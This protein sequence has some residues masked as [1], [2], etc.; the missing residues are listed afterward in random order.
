[1]MIQIPDYRFGYRAVSLVKSE[2]AMKQ[3]VVNGLSALYYHDNI[4]ELVPDG[5]E[6]SRDNEIIQ[7]L[8]G[9]HEGDVFELS[10]E[11]ELYLYYN[12]SSEDNAFVLTNHCNS[13]CIMCPS[14]E[15]ARK[16][17]GAA[18]LQQLL[19][20]VKH[21]P[22][23]AI[24]LTITGGEPYLFGKGIFDFFSALR[25]RFP[26]TEF[27]L[28]T[29]GRV[30]SLP[31]YCYRTN[32]TLPLRT[33]IGI[34][35]HGPNSEIH[36]RITQVPGSFE[37]TN[38]GIKN[39]IA[40]G[41][42]VELRIVVSQLNADYLSQIATLFVQSYKGA[43]SV[44]IMGLEMLG[45][46]AINRA[47]VWLPYRD[48][49]QKAKEAINTLIAHGF[50]VKLY[51]FPLCSVEPAYWSIC[52]KSISEDKVRY[53]ETCEQCRVKDACG[54]LFAGT[55]RLAKEDVEPIRSD[56]NDLFF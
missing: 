11:G 44:K 41:R 35:I 19:D 51:N 33:L 47:R 20:L 25:E 6:V 36:D 43:Q 12:T 28:L 40:L 34:P 22:T 32:E 55:F 21:I 30:F 15:I 52:A 49:F 7:Q 26:E 16:T 50:D 39:M 1:M 13:N 5:V 31:E 10:A 18:S 56:T 2:S 29:N 37:Q 38:I 23:D 17:G 53:P 3:C 48:A 45:S 8:S 27:L 24:H 46:A 42:F 54:G 9:Y 4:L 14:S